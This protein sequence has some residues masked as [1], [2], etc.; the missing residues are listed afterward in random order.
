MTTGTLSYLKKLY[1]LKSMGYSYIDQ[2]IGETANSSMNDILPNEITQLQTTMGQCNLCVL[3]KTRK[4]VLVSKGSKI[5]KLFCILPSPDMMDDSTGEILS[6]K[7]GLLFKKILESVFSLMP[8]NVY[9]T[10]ALKCKVP[11]SQLSLESEIATCKNY[12]LKELQLIRP[13]VIMV[14]GQDAYAYLTKNRGDF[15]TSLGQE[16]NF[17]GKSMIPTYA[18]SELIRNPSYKQEAYKHFL[19]AKRLLDS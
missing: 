15:S 17:Q 3:S 16:M 8:S 13:K 6:G 1:M 18:L 2:D 12:L 11:S 7:S 19:L 5:A 4:H 9:L 14:F 10:Y